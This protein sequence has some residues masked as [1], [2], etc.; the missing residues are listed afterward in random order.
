MFLRLFTLA[1]L[2]L[3]AAAALYFGTTLPWRLA[4]VLSNPE[5]NAP[6]WRLEAGLFLAAPALLALFWLL[7]W[8]LRL[9]LRFVLA[10]VFLAGWFRRL[11]AKRQREAAAK[12]G[13]EAV[14]ALLAGDITAAQAAATRARRQGFGEEE[15]PGASTAKK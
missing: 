13:A 9:L 11:R 12:S 2:A 1:A 3:L 5:T 14:S 7:I 6:A 10:P 15:K 4:V 8:L